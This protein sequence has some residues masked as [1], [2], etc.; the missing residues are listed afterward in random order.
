MND[1]YNVPREPK[2]TTTTCCSFC[3]EPGHN[4]R[5]CTDYRIENGWREILR[6]ADFI[7]GLDDEG[8]ENVIHSLQTFPPLLLTAVAVK[9]AQSY[10]NDSME[11]KLNNIRLWIQ[12]ETARYESLSQ[13]DK[14]AYLHWLDPGTYLPDGTIIPHDDDVPELVTD[15]EDEDDFI[16]VNDINPVSTHLIEPFLLCIESAD[17][18]A[19][20][21]E[22]PICFEEDRTLLDMNTTSCEHSFCHS[23]IMRHLRTKD[24]CPMCRTT[25]RTLQVRQAEHY[26]EVK[27]AFG[28][29]TRHTPIRIFQAP[30]GTFESRPPL[31]ASILRRIQPI[32]LPSLTH[33]YIG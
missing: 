13:E 1:Q 11:T 25:V 31:P 6:R 21:C 2:M 30:D 27:E 32:P 17:E 15:D 14:F 3:D 19:E 4:I 24:S 16:P 18:L 22:C 9:Y 12:H 20:Q 5:T 29:I 28:S 23:C 33:R 7:R 26:D 8:L 10:A